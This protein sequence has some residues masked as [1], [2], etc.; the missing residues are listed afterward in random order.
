LKPVRLLLVLLVVL[1]AGAAPAGAA[2]Y[3]SSGVS[4]A[5]A[6]DWRCKPTSDHPQPVVLVH[7]TFADMTVSW[8]L[9]SPALKRDG[10]CVYALDYGN[11]ATNEIGQSAQELSAFVDKVLAATGA[12]KVDIVGHSQGGMMPRY[13]IKNLGGDTKVDDLVGLAPSNHGTTNQAAFHA[14][15]Q[16]CQ[17]CVEQRAGSP[18]LAG[19]NSGD[20][21]PGPVSY[22]QV[23]T[24]YDEVVTPYTSAF[25]APDTDVTN[26]TLQD[27]CA[28]DVSDHLGISHDP[29][30]LQ[31]TE[32]A[33]G[34]PGSADASFTPNCTG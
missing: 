2:T 27:A 34:R 15:G 5:G 17:A 22:T 19:L 4:P 9:F 1:G 7:G 24:R 18:F 29:I 3:Y 6:N 30:A 26:V 32:N 8:N 23:E 21:S 25:L 11:R 14:S 10:Y 13:Y 16:Y 12:A 31:W 20:E 33:L 28:N